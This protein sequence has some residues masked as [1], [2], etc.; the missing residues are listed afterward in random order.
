VDGDSEL[1]IAISEHNSINAQIVCDGQNHIL[2]NLGD[3]V[4]IRKKQTE[5][6]LIHPSAHSFYETCRSKLHWAQD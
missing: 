6:K 4:R 2:G 5:I 3:K 1:E